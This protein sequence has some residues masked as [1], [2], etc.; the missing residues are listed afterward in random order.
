[1]RRWLRRG[2]GVFAL[3][4]LAGVLWVGRDH[5]SALVR[6]NGWLAARPPL[7]EP[8]PPLDPGV[9]W[10]DAYY[11][12][13]ALDERTWAIGEPRYPQRNEVVHVPGHTPESVALLD[14]EQGWVFRGDA[15]YPGLLYAFLPGSSLAD[16]LWTARRLA[17]L[18]AGTAFY[19]AHGSGE[20]T[21][22]PRLGTDSVLALREA[23]EEIRR[24][25]RSGA[26]VFPR[27][28]PVSESLALAAD[29]IAGD[30]TARGSPEP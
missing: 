23:L 12:V 8:P 27:V 25:E 11:T 9:T 17:E 7:V 5:R 10:H 13:E 22:A 30:W 28:Y 24:G 2:A 6:A 3:L 29:G 4:F 18:P 14:R 1:M 16:Y 26:G 15:L 19:G 21:L 20:T